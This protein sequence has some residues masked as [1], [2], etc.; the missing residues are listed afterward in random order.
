MME[1]PPP[2]MM[3][4]MVIP[5]CPDAA[6]YRPH[7]RSTGAKPL[8]SCFSCLNEIILM[9][10]ATGNLD[11]SN[12]FFFFSPFFFSS[13]LPR[14]PQSRVAATQGKTRH[15]IKSHF[16]LASAAL[17][18]HRILRNLYVECVAG[19][20]SPCRTAWMCAQ[21]RG[22]L[23]RL[24]PHPYEPSNWPMMG[25]GRKMSI[26]RPRMMDGKEGGVA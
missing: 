19:T 11:V 8:V 24:S 1:L 5:G 23:S 13:L 16:G 6:R 7:T 3:M 10:I 18:A 9:L 25:T 17:V 21:Q 2:P 14:Q 4:M 22:H 20:L 15:T 12:P 26:S